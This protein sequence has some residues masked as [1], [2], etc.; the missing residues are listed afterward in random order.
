MLSENGI[1]SLLFSCLS[2]LLFSALLP[3]QT[4]A[5]FDSVN[6]ASGPFPPLPM[7]LRRLTQHRK[8]GNAFR[9]QGFK[10]GHF[11]VEWARWF[12]C[13]PAGDDLL[14]GRCRFHN[15]AVRP[16]YLSSRPI[17]FCDFAEADDL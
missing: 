7:R 16:E 9:C 5:L 3:A 8:P 17:E 2:A 15:P 11:S 4:T 1:K 6:P 13:E 14:F 10:P 12:Q